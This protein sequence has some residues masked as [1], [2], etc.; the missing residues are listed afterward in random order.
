M[1]SYSAGS[2]ELH[3]S[4]KSHRRANPNVCV[5]QTHPADLRFS[6]YW[7]NAVFPC[8][9]GRGSDFGFSRHAASPGSPT[10]WLSALEKHIAEG[11][12]KTGCFTARCLFLHVQVII[13]LRALQLGSPE[14]SHWYCSR[15]VS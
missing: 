13:T 14:I 12:T 5:Q 8:R 2:L 7:R 9:F 3:D 15:V 1:P 11:M 6:D 10:I 4:C